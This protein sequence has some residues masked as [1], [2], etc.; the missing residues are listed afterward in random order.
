[1]KSAMHR[2]S[3]KER[4]DIQMTKLIEPGSC[5]THPGERKEVNTGSQ[6]LHGWQLCQLLKLPLVSSFYHMLSIFSM[7]GRN[8]KDATWSPCPNTKLKFFPLHSNVKSL[9]L[10]SNEKNKNKK[11]NWSKTFE[12]RPQEHKRKASLVTWPGISDGSA[13]VTMQIGFIITSLAY[14]SP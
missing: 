3:R 7:K 1:M 14:A 9:R 13:Y 5:W 11:W 10:C 6:D 2:N 12:T 4:S 8:G